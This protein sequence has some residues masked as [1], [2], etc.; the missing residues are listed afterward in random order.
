MVPMCNLLI[1]PTTWLPT[2]FT[3]LLKPVYMQTVMLW[4]WTVVWERSSQVFHCHLTFPSCNII[5]LMFLKGEASD[6]WLWEQH[7]DTVKIAWSK[8]KQ[9]YPQ[10]GQTFWKK[11]TKMNIHYLFFLSA[12]V[13]W[14]LFKKCSVR[15]LY[16]QTNY[17]SYCTIRMQ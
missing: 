9:P 6:S 3:E 12:R 11:G 10:T 16:K 4:W 8:C 13:V 15:S 7:P 2:S 14:V 5:Q 1:L 17:C